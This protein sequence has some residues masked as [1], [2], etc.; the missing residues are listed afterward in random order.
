MMPFDFFL[1]V[2]VLTSLVLFVIVAVTYWLSNP[3]DWS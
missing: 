2:A 3:R 1:G